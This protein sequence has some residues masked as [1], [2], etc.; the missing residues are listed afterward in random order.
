MD[1]SRA[2]IYVKDREGRYLLVNREWIEA[3]EIPREKALGK[4]DAEIFPAEL[5]TAY[6]SNDAQIREQRTSISMQEQAPVRG[7]LRSFLSQKFPLLDSDNKL[8]GTAGIS[9]DITDLKRLEADLVAA[10]DTAEAATQAKSDFLA[11]MS[12]E[13]RTPMN[14]IIGMSHLCLKT[15]LTSKQRDYIRKVERAAH[16][17]L[18]IINDILDFSKIEAG[19]L[20]MEKIGFDLEDVFANLSTMVGVKAN[21][22]GLEV[23]FRVDP[24]TPLHLVGD[25]L[26]LQQVALNLCSNAVK[27]T[28]KGEIVASVTQRRVEDDEVELEFAISDTG[29]GMTPEQ[30]DKLFKPFSQADASTTRKFGGTGLGLSIS[31]RLV[32]MMGG[33]IRVESEPGKG[34]T[35]SFNAVFGRQERKSQKARHIPSRDLRGMRVLVVDDN[36]SSREILQEM[37]EGMSFEVTVAAS[38]SEGIAEIEAADETEP[39]RLVLMDWRMPEMDGLEA[40]RAIRENEKLVNQPRIILVTAYGNEHLNERAAEAGLLGVLLKPISGSMMFD[41]IVEAFSDSVADEHA[42]EAEIQEAPNYA[43]DLAGLTVLL[44]EDNEINQEV[45]TELLEGIGIK[46]TLAENGKQAVEKATTVRFDGVLMDIQMPEMDGYAATRAIR[47]TPGFD[48]LPIVAMTANAMA[49]DRSRALEAGMNDHVAKPIDPDQLFATIQRWFQ[50]TPTAREPSSS[51]ETAPQAKAVNSPASAQSTLP[52]TLDG[53][54]IEDG[55]RRVGGNRKLYR[56]LLLKFR[57][58]QSDV[59]EEIRSCVKKGDFSTAQRLAHTVKGVAGNV[60][61]NDLHQVATRLDAV[62]KDTDHA[63]TEQWLPKFQAALDRVFTSIEALEADE[64]TPAHSTSATPESAPVDMAALNPLLDELEDLLANDDFEAQK[65]LD[66][67]MEK[68]KGASLADGLAEV[69][70]CL[71]QYDFEAA[72]AK[73]RAARQ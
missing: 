65:H 24:D 41:T 57:R 2:I 13:I 42:P 21:E 52:E 26:R 3:L 4:T 61:A 51:P 66:E 35:F 28:E 59:V 12:H 44:V 5:A 54:D 16:S 11:N 45:A 7:E 25:P 8:F 55:L 38:A 27:F 29:I 34:S 18:G 20:A 64:K 46:V 70:D 37:L 49:G 43:A 60:G 1:N 53:I 67:V 22:K 32:E 31:R 15:D 14:A 9:S 47:A 48:T 63:A 69:S 33:E 58:G 72:L 62:L 71:G 23:L 39:F 17:L 40:A 30:R 50:S 19:K 10:K 73:L 68:A 36:T 56:S 6:M